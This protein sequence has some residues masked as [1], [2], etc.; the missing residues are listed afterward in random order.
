MKKVIGGKRYDTEAAVLITSASDGVEFYKTQKGN[1]FTFH[2]K[3]ME[4]SPMSKKELVTALKEADLKEG[5]LDKVL[6]G[7]FPDEIE[8]A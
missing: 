3:K 7:H 8:D 5:D 2:K 4:I 1:Y 6:E